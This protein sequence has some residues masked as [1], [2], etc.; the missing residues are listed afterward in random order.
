M[1]RFAIF[2]VAAGVAAAVAMASEK[3]PDPSAG[4]PVVVPLV[5]G[6]VGPGAKA[7]STSWEFNPLGCKNL[8]RT[9]SKDLPM[10][11]QIVCVPIDLAVSAVSAAPI[12][13]GCVAAGTA[14][15]TDFVGCRSWLSD[16]LFGGN[17]DKED[18]GSGTATTSGEAKLP[19]QIVNNG[20][21]LII[22][23]G[24]GQQV[25]TPIAPVAAE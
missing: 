6:S 21:T 8:Q 22:N 14:L 16:N 2:V 7:G 9:W 17:K 19:S 3:G 20:G 15:V 13:W 11:A 25:V 10:P 4:G 23:N 1:K 18:S 5:S 24:S 12:Q